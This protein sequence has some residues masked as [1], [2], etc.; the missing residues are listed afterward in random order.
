MALGGDSSF[1]KRKSFGSHGM[2]YKNSKVE[3]DLL[4]VYE[5]VFNSLLL[6]F[7]TQRDCLSYDVFH[8]MSFV[9]SHL[10]TLYYL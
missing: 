5:K 7:F 2:L 10:R 9:R 3:F 1:K 4:E 8:F 6:S